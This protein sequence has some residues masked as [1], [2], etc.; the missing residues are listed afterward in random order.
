MIS[1]AKNIFLD[2]L[3]KRCF[4]LAGISFFLQQEISFTARE[5]KSCGQGEKWFS[6]SRKISRYQKPLR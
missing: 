6:E 5:K 4:F 1:D 2:I 3:T